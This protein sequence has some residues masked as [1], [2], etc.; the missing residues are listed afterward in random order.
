MSQVISKTAKGIENQSINY[1]QFFILTEG[2]TYP[3]LPTQPKHFEHFKLIQ[4]SNMVTLIAHTS[5]L[6]L[7]QLSN[8]WWPIIC[9]DSIIIGDQNIQ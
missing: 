2:G 8:F 9:F 6:E 1:A 4:Q 7:T 5:A 3:Q